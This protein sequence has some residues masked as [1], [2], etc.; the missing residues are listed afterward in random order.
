MQ[1][2]DITSEQ[3]RQAVN[4]PDPRA[5]IEI[6]LNL[7]ARLVVALEKMAEPNVELV[8]EEEFTRRF[9]ES[10]HGTAHNQGDGRA[11]A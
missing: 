4:D 3:I 5:A 2:H 11:G 7:F 8:S 10:Q 9:G 6:T 1:E